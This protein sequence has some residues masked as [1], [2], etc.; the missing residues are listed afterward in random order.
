MK[1]KHYCSILLVMF[2]YT[3]VTQAQQNPF[4]GKWFFATQSS[5]LIMNA[6]YSF[7]AQSPTGQS[8]GSYT[9]DANSVLYFMNAQGQQMM[10]YAVN[11]IHQK[12][13]QRQ[14]EMP[15]VRSVYNILYERISPIIEMRILKGIL[16]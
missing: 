16:R 9:W 8:S 10:Y 4:V 12:K 13:K 5:T 2:L 11:A 14:V 1:N 3:T 15:V 6:D 7:S